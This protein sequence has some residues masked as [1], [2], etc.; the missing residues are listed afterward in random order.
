MRSWPG[1]PTMMSSPPSPMNSSMPPLPM[2]TSWPSIRSSAYRIVVVA[3]RAVRRA[4]LDPVAAF[5]ADHGLGGRAAVGGSRRRRRRRSP[6]K[7]SPA[8]MKS[9]PKPPSSRLMPLPPLMTS[10]PS[11][12]WMTSSPPRSV[13]MSS[14]SPPR[15]WSA[16][17]PPSSR[18]LPPSP[19]S[20]SSPM[21]RDHGVVALGAAEHDMVLARVVQVV[22]FR[23][24]ACSGLSRIT[25]GK[26]WIVAGRIGAAE[27]LR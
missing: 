27:D 20:V 8:M 15:I 2:K 23:R 10:L 11:P 24:P 22:A 7:S 1:P 25:S 21:P 19:H 13:M 16:P 4:G 9:L 6:T 14:P 18:S 17:S 5:V 12:P 26:K 3:R